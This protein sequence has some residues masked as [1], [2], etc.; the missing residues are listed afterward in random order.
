MFRFSLQQVLE[1]RQEVQK[2]CE[3][4]YFQ[5]RE[6]LEQ[7]EAEREALEVERQSVAGQLA[8]LAAGG[9][10][11]SGEVFSP[12]RYLMHQHYLDELT[13][14]IAAKI[15]EGE[16]LQVEAEKKRAILIEALRDV[17]IMEELKK[18]ELKEDEY[19]ERKNEEKMMSDLAIFNFNQR[20][21]E[22]IAGK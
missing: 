7:A 2:S 21:R 6:R 1:Y 14:K 10:P 12:E 11:A 19:F 15:L 8:A 16:L 4:E 13:A 5:A 18:E 20:R 22:K 9:S 17:E 3:R